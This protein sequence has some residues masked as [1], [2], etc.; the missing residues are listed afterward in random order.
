VELGDQAVLDSEHLECERLRSRAR[1][2]L[3]EDS[4]RR[5]SIR[6]CRHVEVLTR[7]QR[8]LRLPIPVPTIFRCPTPALLANKLELMREPE[9]DALAAELEKL[10][11]E[12]R[13]RMLNDL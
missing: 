6:T 7:L 12:E 10:P 2:A 11:P 3:E 8:A 4:E 9:I 1:R 13:A 5:L